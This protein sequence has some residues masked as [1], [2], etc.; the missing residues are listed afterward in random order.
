MLEKDPK[1]RLSIEDIKVLLD[2]DDTRPSFL[3]ELTEWVL[4]EDWPND[5]EDDGIE[6]A[7]DR[8]VLEI[9][10]TDF[11]KKATQTF[12]MIVSQIL[13]ANRCT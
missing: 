6:Y 5:I 7:A 4:E 8:D 13:N 2:F 11:M 3:D 9:Q 10:E 1:E 12:Q